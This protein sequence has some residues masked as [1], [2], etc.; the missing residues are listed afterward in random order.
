VLGPLGTAVCRQWSERAT[1]PTH[2]LCE[3]ALDTHTSSTLG[4]VGQRRA[5][6]SRVTLQQR[7]GDRGGP[8]PFFAWSGAG[9]KDLLAPGGPQEAAQELLAAAPDSRLDVCGARHLIDLV[10]QALLWGSPLLG[11]P[12]EKRH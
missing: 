4:H 12:S 11:K 3:L 7:L 8:L 10:C 2:S 6:V 5:R 9:P 1:V